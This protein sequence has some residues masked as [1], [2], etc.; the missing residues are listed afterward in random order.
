MATYANTEVRPELL[1]ADSE[2]ADRVGQAL[3]KRFE[4]NKE[5]VKIVPAA[6]VKSYL[7][8]N[9]GGRTLSPYDVG[10]HFKADLVVALEISSISLYEPGSSN[11]LFRGRSEM[12]V[13]V[14]DL[15]NPRGEGTVLDDVFRIEY[16]RTVGRDSSGSS[17]IVFRTAFLNRTARDLSRWFSAWPSEER[18]QDMD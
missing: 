1:T 8:Q 3:K 6:R 17:P 15:S 11:T 14:T 9:L 4:D 16:P 18:R 2:L 13:T 12:N 7:N 10:Q 5:K